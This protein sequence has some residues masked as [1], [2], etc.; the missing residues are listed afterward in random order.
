MKK[1]IYLLT[2]TA[3]GIS[4]CN[5]GNK[6]YT[7]SGTIEGE[8]VVSIS[9]LAG[10]IDPTPETVIR[11]KNT[12]ENAITLIFYSATS[13]TQIPGPGTG[14]QF[15]LN[16]GETLEKLFSDFNFES[17]TYFNVYNPS[18]ISGSWEVEI[19]L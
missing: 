15:T 2:V 4:A 1:L 11:L 5:S 3:L 8:K 7:I 12:S 16:P 14:P 10:D 6:G 9:E 13:P 19:E 17:F 18:A